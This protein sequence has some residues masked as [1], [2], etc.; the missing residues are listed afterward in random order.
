MRT[1]HIDPTGLKLTEV[2]PVYPVNAGFKMH[3]LTEFIFM[4]ARKWS[5]PKYSLKDKLIIKMCDIK[6]MEYF[7]AVSECENMDLFVLESCI[8]TIECSWASANSLQESVISF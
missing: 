6:W 2:C 5:Q 7:S 1:H 4:R 8:H 3:L